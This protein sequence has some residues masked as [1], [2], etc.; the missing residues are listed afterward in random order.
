MGFIYL[1]TN[2]VN[3]KKY[4]GLTTKTVEERWARHIYDATVRK[5]DFYFHRA[6]R[7][8]GVDNFKVEKIEECL[9]EELSEKEKFYIQQYDSFYQNQKGYNLTYGGDGLST[10]DYKK[11]LLL[12][13]QGLSAKEIALVLDVNSITICHFLKNRNISSKEIKSRGSHFGKKNEEKKV[14]QYNFNGELMNIFSS[15]VEASIITGYNKD[16]IAAACRKFYSSANGYIWT[17]EDEETDIQTLISRVPPSSK[18]PVYQYNLNGEL[19]QEF[20]SISEA[21]R[22][23]GLDK[24]AISHSANNKEKVLTAGGFLW[25][26][27]KNNE[28]ILEKIINYNNRY[29]D[30]KKKI[31]QYDKEGN[32]IA[33]FESVTAA[34]KAIGKESCRSSIAKVC[35]GKLQTSCGFIWKYST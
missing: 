16:Y 14:Y 34:A 8:Y 10:I 19:I 17:Y 27:E 28:E 26:K 24:T 30:R 20:T 21:S 32:F 11:V 29:N 5:D 25:S 33:E 23:T 4:I 12:W 7:K 22:L 15:S 35:Q 1:V 3:N 31:Q 2:I 18:V 9:D 6:I 13:K